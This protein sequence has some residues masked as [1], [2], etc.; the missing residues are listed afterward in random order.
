MHLRC[1]GGACLGALVAGAL[2]LGGRGRRPLEVRLERRVVAQGRGQRG[3]GR[4][5]H[6][7]WCGR[8]YQRA[9]CALR[10]THRRR[11][12][13]RCGGLRGK[14]TRMMG[15]AVSSGVW[16]SAPECGKRKGPACPPAS[17][18]A[19]LVRG[20]SLADAA[21]GHVRSPFLTTVGS[22]TGPPLLV[23]AATLLVTAAAAATAV[24]VWCLRAEVGERMPLVRRSHRLC[25]RAGG[26]ARA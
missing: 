21:A 12:R 16:C 13:R 8:P 23:F 1:L 10:L 4:R 6:G 2:T 24:A 17:T 22:R 11:R 9:V 5:G 15:G 7:C 20:R 19:Y 25:L 14:S 26:K 3:R 18:T